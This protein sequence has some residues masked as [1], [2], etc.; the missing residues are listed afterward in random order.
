MRPYARGERGRGG[1]GWLLLPGKEATG[2]HQGGTGA[3]ATTD[4]A[5]TMAPNAA[6]AWCDAWCTH[7]VQSSMKYRER[8]RRPVQGAEQHTVLGTSDGEHIVAVRLG[9]CNATSGVV[10]HTLRGADRSTDEGSR[11]ADECARCDFEQQ[12]LPRDRRQTQGSALR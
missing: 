2:T 8:K 11:T 6:R 10:R 9:D 7:H 5:P 12:A 1:T 3:K 4:E